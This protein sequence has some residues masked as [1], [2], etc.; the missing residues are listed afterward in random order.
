[1]RSKIS[2]I[3]I[4]VVLLVLILFF[5][6]SVLLPAHPSSNV[7]PTSTL[8]QD[9]SSLGSLQVKMQPVRKW[10]VLDPEVTAH[11]VLVQS[12]DDRF[13]YYHSNTTLLWPAA[14]L[15]KLLTA[16]VVVEDIGLDKKVEITEVA[17][18]TEGQAGG[19]KKGEVYLAR[20]LVK[21]MLLTSSNDAAVAFQELV[22]GEN[23][24]IT[25]LNRKMR[26]IGIHDTVLFDGS[27]L[28]DLNQTTA[29]DLLILLRYLIE[30][31][32]E[33]L[34]WTRLTDILV[35]PLNSDH[36]QSLSNINPFVNRL[37][38]LG[39]KTGTSEAAKQ[40]LAALFSFRDERLVIILLG[41][42]D[43]VKDVDTILRW[44]DEAYDFPAE[45]HKP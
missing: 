23:N 40:N 41:S 33:I 14:S 31:R 26:T 10:D 24:F 5:G 11:A 19:L 21:I 44:I 39:G 34:Q 16:L 43:R 29:A 7:H 13:P 37:A 35:Q 8:S 38:F 12:L 36:S 6:R 28:S 25:L 15:T 2:L 32:P 4:G 9:F 1:M 30:K 3:V 22:G 18:R 20:D 42:V 27:G 17:T 45:T